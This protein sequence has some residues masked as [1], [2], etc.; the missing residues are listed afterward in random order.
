MADVLQRLAVLPGP[1]EGSLARQRALAQHGP[2]RVPALALRLGPVLG[3]AGRPAGGFLEQGDVPRGENALRGGGLPRVHGHGPGFGQPAAGQVLHGRP[4]S[5]ADQH[6]VRLQVTAVGQDQVPGPPVALHADR[7]GAEVEADPFLLGFRLHPAADPGSE[8]LLQRHL[9]GGHHPDLQAALPQG[10]GRLQA[11]E[12]GPQHRHAAAGRQRREQ[13]VGVRQAAQ[14]VAARQVDARHRRAQ[15]HAAGGQQDALTSQAGAVGQ[16][17]GAAARV[18]G[19]HPAAGGQLDLQAVVEFLPAQGQPLGR[20]LP[21]EVVLGERG[22]VVGAHGLLGQQHDAPA[23]PLP[24][25]G[26][27]RGRAGRPPADDQEGPVVRAGRHLDPRRLPQA[28]PHLAPLHLHLVDGQVAQGGRREEAAVAQVE[29]GV[30]RGAGEGVPAQRP[31]GQVALVMGA[32]RRAGVDPASRAHQQHLAVAHGD[33]H[34]PPFHQVGLFRRLPPLPAFHGFPPGR[35]DLP[36]LRSFSRALAPSAAC[37]VPPGHRG[38]HQA[39]AAAHRPADQ[40]ALPDLGDV[41]P[42][43]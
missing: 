17:Q 15:R 24:A 38:A 20:G 10:G 41:R 21:G 42:C 19:G 23:V 37:A 28:H 31:P 33:L 25:Q 13:G 30:V 32:L 4:H 18:Q 39:D 6:D 7:G 16:G 3:A 1:E 34:Q 40:D 11:D 27:R 22:P 5:H 35:A 36:L 2:G 14:G 8:H 29:A 9:L 12:A 26:L 43:T